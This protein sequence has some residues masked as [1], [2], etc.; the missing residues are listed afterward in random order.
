MAAAGS[1]NDGGEVARG[2]QG[3]WSRL[4]QGP[5]HGERGGG[6]L[7]R[8][9]QAKGRERHSKRERKRKRK[10]IK[11][12]IKGQNEKGAKLGEKTNKEPRREMEPRKKP[13][14]WL[15]LP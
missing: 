3:V 7:S 12:E 14:R 13:K 4:R 8:G 6:G 15:D 9:V 1:F 5:G 2:G 11:F 10:E